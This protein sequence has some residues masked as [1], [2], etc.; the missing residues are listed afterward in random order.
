MIALLVSL[1]VVSAQTDE[2]EPEPVVERTAPPESTAKAVA[3]DRHWLD[4]YFSVGPLR[5]AVEKFRMEDWGGA[6]QGFTKSLAVLPKGS[7]ER[8]P[9]LF[10]LAMVNM[11]LSKWQ[12]AGDIFESLWESHSLLAPYHA[13]YAARCRVRRGDA[14][15]AILWADRVPP[16]T[17]P[18]AE[19]LLVR[20][21]S[22]VALGRW[23]EVEA[24]AGRF[25]ERFPAGP[26]RAE[27]AFRR[28][29]ALEKLAR[30]REELAAAYRP[31]LTESPLEVWATRATQRLEALAAEAT[32]DEAVK[33]RTRT[34]A[35]QVARGM[36]LFGRNANSDSEAAFAAALSAPG[37][38]PALSCKA[39]Y[40]RA[41][42]VWKQR[43][44]QR[45]IPLFTDA[46]GACRAAG[47]RDLLVK[48]M[49]QR[50]RCLYAATDRAT[51]IRLF[52]Q[53]EKEAPD[54]SYAD[55]ARVRAAEIATED[56][57]E[58]LAESLLKEV[59]T[60]YPQGDLLG[61]SLWRLA[62]RAW[63]GSRFDE[64]LGFLEDN[65]RR[66]P[67]E[68]LWYAEGR[69]HYWKGRIFEKQSKK[70][71]AQAAYERAVREYPLSVYALFASERLRAVAPQ[72]RT[73]LL[74]ELRGTT[75]NAKGADGWMFEPR[76]LFG[77]PGFRRAVE[78]ARLGMGNDARRELAKLGVA[79][80]ETRDIARKLA[81]VEPGQQDV[82]W[83]TAILLDRSRLWHVS[84]AIPRYSVGVF[85]ET[86][87][88]GRGEAEWRIAYPRAFAHLVSRHSRT[89]NV[90]EALQLAIM[91]EESAFNPRIESFA[92]AIGLTQLIMST[93]QRFAPYRITRETLLD[94]AKNVEIGSRFLGFLIKHY[95]GALPLAVAGYNAGESAVDRWL[96][97]RSHLE[98]DE[99]IETIPYDETRNYTKRVLAS[100]AAYSWLY[101]PQQPVPGIS[102]AL[103]G[104]SRPKEA[105]GRP[106]PRRPR[107]D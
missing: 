105:S 44:R 7:P 47:N 45:A 100:F 43:Q 52:A 13:Y 23:R 29:E 60:R 8:A 93:A 78:L 107:R 106:A 59:P 12:A 50:A 95:S 9:A 27:A 39:R 74:R 76:P 25:L 24:E 81:A 4:P 98:M 26:R 34:A 62:F 84:H 61:E 38:D 14:E 21:D 5:A 20:I 2:V 42:S 68:T 51:A 55:D 63:Q 35:E 71:Q 28:A 16:R 1:L 67:H 90:P 80:P 48:S 57:D 91:R 89:N 104:V 32:G 102:F 64:A 58:A 17:V 10:L 75:A 22:L 86:Y 46:E 82:Y 97:E 53:I 77:E 65:L 54:H 103:G 79:P 15:G 6:A 99:F 72:A 40:H 96:R 87:P 19:A 11:N 92:N 85:R 3:F 36:A 18:E 37:L 88:S 83:I 94:P 33:L 66:I 41:Q 69:A 49:Y 73:A 101:F 31:I 30:P 70:E 56:G